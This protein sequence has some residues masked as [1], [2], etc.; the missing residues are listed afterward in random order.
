[1]VAL[2]SLTAAA[3]CAVV[4]GCVCTREYAPTC[5]QMDDGTAAT[6]S[7][8]CMAECDGAGDELPSD[9]CDDFSYG[10]IC[11]MEYAPT[12]RLMDDGTTATFS[13]PCVAEC[14]G[15]GEEELHPEECDDYPVSYFPDALCTCPEIYAPVCSLPVEGG[16]RSVFYENSC[17]AECDGVE[18]M[19]EVDMTSADAELCASYSYGYGT[20]Y[21]YTLLA[22]DGALPR[23]SGL[24]VV[25]AAGAAL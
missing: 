5:R 10:C 14:D 16:E 15:A 24:L 18:D 19:V 25:L 8:P 2:R 1:M 11:T 23:S 21:S 13:N 4:S 17:V 6:F 7:N 22:Y 12:C 9:Q 20:S 3:L